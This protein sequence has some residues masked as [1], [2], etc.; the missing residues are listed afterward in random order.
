D[1]LRERQLG[2]LDAD[3]RAGAHLVAHING[4]RRIVADDKDGEARRDAELRLEPT[5]ALAASDANLGRH[6]P[7]IDDL[8]GFQIALS[9]HQA[10]ITSLATGSR[11]FLPASTVV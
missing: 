2:G 7:A 3:I 6:F 1:I 11:A 8:C 10:C 4:G 9:H 5:D